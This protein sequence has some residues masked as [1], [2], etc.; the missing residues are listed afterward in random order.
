MPHRA[1]KATNH[2]N[3]SRKGPH[4]HRIITAL[5]LLEAQWFAGWLKTLGEGRLP[6]HNV[7]GVGDGLIEIPEKLLC[8]TQDVNEL[9]S[10]V[11]EG[12]NTFSDSSDLTE[13]LVER[14]ILAPTNEAVDQVNSRVMSTF[15]PHEPLGQFLSHDMVGPNDDPDAWPI[16]FLN[17]QEMSSLPPHKLEL[18]RA[19]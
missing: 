5:I 10:I 11:Y 9:I 1:N 15:R 14:A 3:R 17:A 16:D 7:P 19:P 13:F 18:M 8:P 12:V 2:P 6:L 4:N